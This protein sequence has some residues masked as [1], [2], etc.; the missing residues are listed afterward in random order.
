MATCIG[1]LAICVGNVAKGVSK[2]TK[3]ISM[4]ENQKDEKE[5]YRNNFAI[6]QNSQPTVTKLINDFE[7]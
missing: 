1:K 2:I 3:K 5:P 7:R 4:I 6:G